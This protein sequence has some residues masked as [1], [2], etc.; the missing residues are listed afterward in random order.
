MRAMNA[1][2]QI[3]RKAE[4]DLWADTYAAINR[5]RG[6]CLHHFTQT[7]QAATDALIALKAIG[8]PGVVPLRPLAG[9]RYLDLAMLLGPSGAFEGKSPEACKLLEAFRDQ[10][11]LRSDLAHGVASIALQQ[12][13]K[14][15]AIFRRTS[16]RKNVPE[17][18]EQVYRQAAAEQ[19]LK[20]LKDLPGRLCT[21]LQTLRKALGA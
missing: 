2:V 7:E 9:H 4:D 8:G 21:T 10:E 18:T 12:N 5:W 19:R 17:C 16:I 20:E 3:N 13:G 6:A 15:I 11:G 1:P 14:W